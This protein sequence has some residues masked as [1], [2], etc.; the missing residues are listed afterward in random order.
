MN[1]TLLK[2]FTSNES[3]ISVYTIS[4]VGIAQRNVLAFGQKSRGGEL[5]S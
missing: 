1:L 5:G 2:E 4:S 3:H